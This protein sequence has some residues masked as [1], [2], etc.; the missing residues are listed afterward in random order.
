M[1]FKT[2]SSKK[3]NE[4]A[5]QELYVGQ[6]FN[7]VKELFNFL[8]AG[9]TSKNT[10][11][12]SERLVQ[13]YL[14]YE[15]KQRNHV[16][17]IEIYSKP[18]PKN[19]K[20]FDKPHEMQNEFQNLLFDFLINFRGGSI[21]KNRLAYMLGCISPE[22]YELLTKDELEA[23]KSIMV[24]DSAFILFRRELNEL[25]GTTFINWL[26]KLS[27]K[28]VIDF[29]DVVVID[30]V[31]YVQGQREYTEF[32]V[33]REKLINEL[34]FKNYS[35]AVFGYSNK[36][37]F[38]EKFKERLENA[39]I[40]GAYIGFTLRNRSLIPEVELK[41][42]E[43]V[44]KNFNLFFCHKL[45]SRIYN[46]IKTTNEN[47]EKDMEKALDEIFNGEKATPIKHAFKYHDSVVDDLNRLL[48]AC[49]I[50]DKKPF[51][52][53]KESFWTPENSINEFE[54]EKN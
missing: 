37:N 32:Y 13:Q 25:C 29:Y 24:Y 11:E 26:K 18:K 20:R 4:N 43:G 50:S 6:V 47:H 52:V 33:I 41:D 42:L 5:L 14:L 35:Q 2:M 45:A 54:K 39:G 8:G 16:E 40:K 1:N 36:R 19:D 23:A 3:I 9:Y 10:K 53:S 44:R 17:I 38:Y 27:T 21:T 28:G 46:T 48:N 22:I 34:G 12:S 15:Q 51:T 49:I 30:D 7:S 31:S